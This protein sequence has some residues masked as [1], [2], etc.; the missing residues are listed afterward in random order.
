MKTISHGGRRWE[1]WEGSSGYIGVAVASRNKQIPSLPRQLRY[2][3]T[4]FQKCNSSF[5]L[6]N[7]KKST[8]VFLDKL[9]ISIHTSIRVQSKNNLLMIRLDT[10]YVLISQ[11]ESSHYCA[12]GNHPTHFRYLCASP[13]IS[14]CD[15]EGH[16][17]A[18]VVILFA[19]FGS[20]FHSWRPC[21]CIP[22][23]SNDRLLS[24]IFTAYFPI[25]LL[26]HSKFYR[27]IVFEKM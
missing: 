14:F 3:R 23:L 1:T 20:Y 12:F 25:L 24:S 8:H 19:R 6:V 7:N 15:P 16:I 11:S 4:D 13:Q 10:S 17:S 9:R 2:E 27:S 21:R 22:E 5:T 18:D 26:V